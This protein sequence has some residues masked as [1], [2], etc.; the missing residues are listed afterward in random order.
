MPPLRQ[1]TFKTRAERGATHLQK[2]EQRGGDAGA[3]TKRLQRDRRGDR[4]D[5]PH[6]GQE[7][8]DPAGNRRRRDEEVVL[9]VGPA[10][11]LPGHVDGRVDDQVGNVHALGPQVARQRFSQD[12]LRRLGWRE[13][14]KCCLA[15][16]RRG[17]G[18]DDQ[19]A[20]AGLHHRRLGKPRQV[21]QRHRVDLEVALQRLRVDLS[22]LPKPPP[23]ALWTTTFGAP[24]CAT[25]RSSAARRSVSRASIAPRDRRRLQSGAQRRR[26]YPLSFALSSNL[27]I[28]QHLFKKLPCDPKW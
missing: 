5:E 8:Q 19:R 10:L 2:P 22:N 21:E 17:V 11:A 26:R 4:L 9:G 23:T 18:G 7:R 24:T 27:T 25:A 3:I 12:T 20:L 6:A 15:P 1:R 16:L 14:G 13:A 28:N